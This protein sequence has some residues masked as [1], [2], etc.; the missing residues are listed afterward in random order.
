MG[1]DDHRVRDLREGRRTGREKAADGGGRGA[2]PDGAGLLEV[3]PGAG[4]VRWALEGVGVQLCW[5]E[6]WLLYR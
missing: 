2:G 5:K 1:S 4:R 3:A 6:S